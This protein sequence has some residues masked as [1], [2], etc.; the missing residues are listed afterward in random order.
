MIKCIICGFEFNQKTYNQK[1]CSKS[2]SEEKNK[3]YHEKY[4]KS[5]DVIKRRKEYHNSEEYKKYCKSIKRKL[6]RQEYERSDRYKVK[7][8]IIDLNRID[9]LNDI[10]IKQNIKQCIKKRGQSIA[11]ITPEMIEQKRLVLKIKRKIKQ[12][13]NEKQS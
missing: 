10:Y 1:C 6:Q 7:K 3:R 4:E 2:C 9:S 11:N 12:F 8:R 5:D 13:K